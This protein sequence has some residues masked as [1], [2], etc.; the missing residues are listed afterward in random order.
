MK[1]R[2]QLAL[3]GCLASIAAHLYLTM[4]YYPLKFGFASGQSICNLNAKFDCDAVSASSYASLFGMPLALW[5]AAT[6]A[7]LFVLILLSWLEWSEYP[8]RLKRW[9]LALAAASFGAS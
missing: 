9:T 1:T 8:E 2:I 7:V 3:M 6:N 5:G 4:H